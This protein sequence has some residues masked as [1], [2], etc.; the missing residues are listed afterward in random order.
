MVTQFLTESEV[1]VRLRERRR[2]FK[3]FKAFWQDVRRVTGMEISY[4]HLFN[5]LKGKQEG[6]D[7]GRSPNEC[8]LRYLGG[9]AANVYQVGDG[10][11]GRVGNKPM[12]ARKVKR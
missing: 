2:P 10:D 9:S 6:G 1:V 8:V 5:I 4:P 11:G 12:K 3:T 7:N